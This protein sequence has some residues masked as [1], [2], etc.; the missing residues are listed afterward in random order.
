MALFG[1]IGEFHESQEP[2]SQYVQR[3]EQFFAANDIA[4]SKKAAVFLA[5]IGPNAFHILSNLVAPR[6]PGEE[7]YVR[8]IEVMSEFYN[9]KPLV[10]VQRY[11]F[12]SRFRQSD[13]SVSAFVAELRNL[14]KECDFGE[15]LEENLRD[16]LVCGI[17]D[18]VIQ[19]RLL[20]EQNLTFKK[21]FEIAQ[22]HE[23][24]AKNIATLH[25]SYQSHD[26]HKLKDSASSSYQPCYRC[27]QSGHRDVNCRFRTA[28]CYYCGKVG[29]IKSVCRSRKHSRHSSNHS[30]RSSTDHSS[31]AHPSEVKQISEEPNSTEEYTLFSIPSGS[32]TPLYATV[33]IDNS[34]LIMEIDTGASFSVISKATYNKLF[35]SRPLQSTNVKLK[36]YTGEP[37]HV[38][39]QITANV[40]YQNKKYNLLLIVAGEEGPSLLGRDWLYSLRLDWNTILHLHHNNLSDIL[41]KYSSVFSKGLGTLKGFK[42]KLYVNNT[43][44]IFCKARPVPYAIRSQVEAELEKLVKQKILEPVPFSDWAAPIVPVMKADK[45]SIRICGDFKLTLNRVCKVD[46]YPI[47]KIEDLFAKLSGGVL[48]SKIDLSQ[49]YQQLELEEESKQFTVI[50]THRGLFRFNRLPFGISSAPGI[51]QR[52]MDS[53]LSGIPGVIVYLDDILISGVSEDDHLHT[54]KVVLERLQSAGLHLKQ[55][56]CKFLV[57]SISYLGHKIDA[58]GLHPLSDKIKAI[59]NASVPKTV[60]ELKA[61]LGLMNYYGKFIPNIAT[62]LHP[63]Y[64]LLNSSV[65]W[66]WTQER[67]EAFNKAKTLLTS[68]SVLIHFD[69][70]K[71]LMVSCDAS[72][73]GVGAVLSHKL[74]DGS[75]RPIAFASRTLSSAEKNYSQIEKETLACVFGVKK[76]HSYLYGRKFTLITDHKPLLTLLHEHHAIPTTTSCRIQRWALTLSMYEYSVS[77]KPSTSHLNADALSRLPLSDVPVDP[78]VPP[79]TVLLLEQ[80]LESP[81]TVN[82]I[83]NWTQRDPTLAKVHH[84]IMSGWPNELNTTDVSLAPYWNRKMEL[85]TQEGVILWG[86]RV[87]VPPQGRDYILEELHAGHPGIAHMKKIARMFVWWPHMDSNIETCVKSCSECQSQ[88]PAPPAS[89]IHP[90]MWPTRPWYR[91]HLDFAGPFMGHM[92]LIVIDAHSKWLEVRVMDSTTSS[93]VISTLR[94]IFAQFGLPSVIVTDNGRNFTST[95][96]HKF[97]KKNGIKHI[98]SSPYHPSSNGLAERAVQS[99]KQSLI[100]LKEGSIVDRVSHVLFHSH[101][102]P[103]STTGLSPAELLMGRRLRSRLD[104]LQPDIEAHV[105]ERQS[106]QQL[107]SNRHARSREFRVGEA[108]YVRNFGVGSKWVPGHICSFVGNVSVDVAL[109]DGRKFR[110]HLDHIRKRQ[111]SDI[112]DHIGQPILEHIREPEISLDPPASQTNSASVAETEQDV[113]VTSTSNAIE[114]HIPKSSDLSQTTESRYPTRDRKSSDLSQATES[115]YPT[116]DRRPPDRYTP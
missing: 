76:F 32:R 41:Q 84:F 87:V 106:K 37:L 69:P 49:A 34:S 86:N 25:G 97:L 92:F 98:L 4:D 10:T 59:T 16:R 81:I 78:P 21:A 46:R 114:T 102:T 66:S 113:A 15:R 43:K 95:E 51:F 38:H 85:S 20:S 79:E 54:L 5:T 56:K 35:P 11:R 70:Q 100:K 18:E 88:R 19:K 42:A 47:P 60:T 91:L 39:G 45:K 72:A 94:S 65:P 40:Q 104:L 13:E 116:R 6:Q 82:E 31:T 55:D 17:S 67:D 53:L 52:A 83:R 77:F 108:V 14:A 63:L 68:A 96:F 105:Y 61:F 107:Y 36:T 50:N 23:S 57:P 73:Y 2:W 7:T 48:F 8:L 111:D 12:Y 115:R 58:E 109:N 26:V 101:L 44:P 3:L 64:Q 99:F 22:S 27:G 28:T 9:P 103:H 33:L 62:I 71:D 74:S 112:T 89:P 80:I 93:A 29:H 90:W 75:E 24:A 110:R 1:S 30:S